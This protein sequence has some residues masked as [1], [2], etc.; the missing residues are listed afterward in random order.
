MDGLLFRD[1]SRTPSR[2]NYLVTDPLLHTNLWLFRGFH[3]RF[4]VV[5]SN[6]V[7]APQRFPKRAH[8]VANHRVEKE[9]TL[10]KSIRDRE[11]ERNGEERRMKTITNSRPND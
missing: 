1:E 9:T 8:Q 11:M 3:L 5:T 10:H 7:C 6:M 4:P 2:I